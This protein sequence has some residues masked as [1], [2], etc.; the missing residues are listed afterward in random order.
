M[1]A[2][3]RCG[4]EPI[5]LSKLENP[6]LH[7]DIKNNRKNITNKNLGKSFAKTFSTFNP[8]SHSILCMN[9]DSQKL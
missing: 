1:Y 2:H 4:Q 9:R 6:S 7:I 3:A 5:D 8:D